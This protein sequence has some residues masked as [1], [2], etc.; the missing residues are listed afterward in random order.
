MTKEQVERFCYEFANLCTVAVR[1]NGG[2]VVSDNTPE[3]FYAMAYFM[4]W[5]WRQDI[6][7]EVAKGLAYPEKEFVDFVHQ[8]VTLLGLVEFDENDPRNKEMFEKAVGDRYNLVK[9]SNSEQY[10]WSAALLWKGW[11]IAFGK[12]K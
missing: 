8:A 4:G 12:R 6:L 7:M 9:K 2:T 5:K 10:A 11:C 3:N 1:V